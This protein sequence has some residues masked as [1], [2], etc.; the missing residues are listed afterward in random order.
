MKLR[1]LLPLI[2]GLSGTLS[3]S[4]GY[5]RSPDIKDNTIVFT[6]EGDLWLS[7]LQSGKAKRLTTH[8]AEEKQAAIS[9]DGKQVA[10]AA[11]YEG[12]TEV[13]VISSTGGIPKR[14]S[15]ENSSVRVHGWTTKGEV[16]YSTNNRVGP[17]GNWTL[18]HVNPKNLIAKSIPLAD[19]IEGTIDKKGDY[20]YFIQ[21]GMQFSGDNTKVYRG[22]AKGEMWRFKLGS[23]K[24]AKALTK[25]HIGSVR[26]PMIHDNKLYFI[27]DASGNE[28]I[29]SMSLDGSN[30]TQVT[31]YKEWPIRSAKINND[32]I[33]YQLGAD[34]KVLNLKTKKSRI[35]PI[36]LTSDYPY[37]R[38]RWL[39][40]PLKYLTSSRMAGDFKKVVVT[41]RGKVAVAGIDKTR[42]VEVATNPESRTRR[43]L[44]SHDGK[45]VYAINDASG[46]LEI[47]KFAADGS[48]KSKQLT[49]DGKIFR[50][51]IYLSPNGKWIAH[52]DKSGNLWLLNLKSGKNQKIL[53]ANSG[54]SPFQNVVWSSDSKLI[55]VTRDHQDNERSRIQLYSLDNG[56]TVMLTSDK[57]N[58][59]SPA[60]SPDGNWLYF[61]SARHF[62]A[63]PPSPWGDRNLGPA[64]DRRNQIFA[65]ALKADAKFPFQ[66]P[67]EL[68]EG[69]KDKKKEDESDDEKEKGN[70]V[71]WK[72]LKDRLWQV[73]VSSG[74]Y[75][76][77][78]VNDSHLFVQDNVTE[79]GSTPS[80]KSIKIKPSTKINTFASGVTYYEMSDD[81]KSLF[82]RKQGGNN[83]NMFIVGA[84]DKFPKDTKNSKVI[85]KDWQLAF[86]PKEEW[87]QIFHDAW[88]MHRDSLYD[89]NMRGLDWEKVKEK[90][91]P[92]L[93][94]LTD[95]YELNDIL[96]QM[97]GELNALH[98]Q[99]RGGD[100]PSDSNAAKPSYL[101]ATL[102][103]TKKGVAIDD[104]Y[105]HE[106]EL[107]SM[108]PPLRKPGVDAQEK[109]I[110]LSINSIATPT[111]AKVN[112]L[113]RN[114]AGK[115]V[116]LS[117]KR[118]KK[119]IKTVVTPAGSRQDFR[120][121]Y[122]SW[123]NGNRNKVEKASNDIG[124]LHLYAMGSSD[125]A[126]FAREF[127]ANYQKN[128]LII[129]VRRNRGG[130]IDSWIIEKLLRKAWAFWHSP[131]GRP[132]TNMQQTFRGHLVVLA[133]EF[134]YSDGETFT[135]GVKALNLA[136]VIGKQTAGAGVWLR[137]MNR[138][139]DNGIARVAE[140]PQYAMDGRWIV[141][142]YGVEPT[143][144]VDNLPH[145]TFKGEDAQLETAIK[146]LKKKMKDSPIP[147]LK[148]KPF[149]TDV[150]TPAMDI[151]KK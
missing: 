140:F 28:N 132:Y 105:I 102:V 79:P 48:Q 93:N 86:N 145:A 40:Q 6:A 151:L 4:T 81:G 15:F 92:L 149:P 88:L 103:Q 34:L 143:I 87:K 8:P 60:F 14:I 17:T 22:G 135:A 12:S 59:H 46:E 91:E 144:E 110:I 118:G 98:S 27:S 29:W 94:K 36:S 1:L 116:L 125:I 20:I 19:A 115:Q 148:T 70:T 107:P 23:N 5:Y 126:S 80:I 69:K 106:A 95:R 134:T 101:G 96:A 76:N 77:L 56:K 85:S 38:E 37:L 82:V 128:G 11:N 130:N 2:C 45:W 117:L 139:T 122:N 49:K 97:M 142:G 90:Y 120:L 68:T 54:L 65:Y 55:A 10:Y 9:P 62:Q 83:A 109:D 18:R 39:N 21:Y 74:N 138:L 42:L 89:A 100:Y 124:Y 73:P 43:A 25:N 113:L 99:V 127:Y 104:I 58:S 112:S 7:N 66:P 30:I 119:T 121:R 150:N 137:G 63:T 72:G 147:E 123:V 32:Q 3:A 71:D 131:I 50:W 47:W 35:V 44:L 78:T 57:Y 33:I 31:Q 75:Y 136:P 141:E 51:N 129:D 64:F 53:T 67:T 111:I 133:D 41:A 24:E 26:T 52:D 13:Y 61:L 114:Q 16:L 146:Y 84:G 108:A